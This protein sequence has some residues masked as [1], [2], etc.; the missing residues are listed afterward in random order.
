MRWR[1]TATGFALALALVFCRD[2][3]SSGPNWGR[4]YSDW[5]Q[6]LLYHAVPRETLLRYGEAPLW[7]PWLCLGHPMLGNPQSRIVTPWFA[8]HL[9]LGSVAALKLEIVGHA[10]LAVLA[11]AFLARTLRVSP[12][13]SLMAGAVFG[14]C[15]AYALHL[16]EGHTW[17]M[18]FAYTPLALGALLRGFERLR[19]AALGGVLLALTVLEGGIY[20]AP[21]TAMAML[22]L[23]AEACWT[24]RSPRPLRALGLALGLGTLLASVKLLPMLEL[25]RQQPRLVES[26]ERLPLLGLYHVLLEPLQRMDSP[27]QLWYAPQRGWH[28]YGHYVG[29][30]ALALAAL[31]ALRAGRVR[32]P[33]LLLAGVFL[34]LGLG[35]FGASAPWALLHDHLPLF[36][37]LRQP[38]RFLSLF[39]LG[40]ALLAGAGVEGVRD[41]LARRLRPRLVA[42]LLPALV[43]LLALQQAL[44]AGAS[45]RD[46]FPRPPLEGRLRPFALAAGSFFAMYPAFLANV[47]TAVN[48]YEYTALLPRDRRQDPSAAAT[49]EEAFERLGP[50]DALGLAP[51][52]VLREASSDAPAPGQLRV[53]EASP[54]RIAIEARPAHPARLLVGQIQDGNWLEDGRAVASDG[55]LLSVPLDGPR[56]VELRYRPR[57]ASVGAALSLAGALLAAAAWRRL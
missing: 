26:L 18:A 22:L 3:A 20:P 12:T 14:A 27:Y 53:L 55:G 11:A 54:S 57:S 17:F 31:G 15:G 41:A 16:N 44:V 48:C 1:L 52:A 38:T 8:L 49:R 32:R 42:A 28:E 7:N 47:G 43:G 10:A 45:F 4:L 34:T 50:P 39:V 6:H 46:A 9:V 2:V 33:A 40:L 19:W 25:L 24:A 30:F 36:A 51:L 35:R 29:P 13:G 23:S 5:D 21:Y 37:S 56:T